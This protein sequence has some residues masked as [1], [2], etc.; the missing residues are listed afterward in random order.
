MVFITQYLLVIYYILT[1]HL[2][3]KPLCLESIKIFLVSMIFEEDDLHSKLTLLVDI[4]SLLS[5]IYIVQVLDICNIYVGFLVGLHC[6]DWKNDTARPQL[7]PITPLLSAFCIS[8]NLWSALPYARTRDLRPLCRQVQVR[9]GRVP[10]DLSSSSLGLFL[11]RR[12]S[13]RTS[14]GPS[15]AR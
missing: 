3:F 14:P 10:R 4:F 7:T 13:N 6:F 8:T 9:P 15:S 11:F 5:S 12:T 1:M 2:A